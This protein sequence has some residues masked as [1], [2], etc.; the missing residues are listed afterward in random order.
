MDKRFAPRPGRY[1]VM[2]DVKVSTVIGTGGLALTANTT[3]T[4]RVS[5]PVRRSW[6]ESISI[7]NGTVGL[8]SDGTILATV[9]HRDNVG[10]SNIALTAATS[11]EVDFLAA[12]NKVFSVPLLT[13]LTDAQ[14][15]CQPGDTVYVDV[16]NNSAAI[17]TQPI[18]NL[19]QVEFCILE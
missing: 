12:N 6:I 11:L 5:T 1:G 18:Q 4:Y 16:V 14:R 19:V 13:T 8:D 9:F 15:I 3:T 7:L 17:D 2:L 10:S